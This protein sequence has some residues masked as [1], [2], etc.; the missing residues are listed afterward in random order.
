MRRLHVAFTRGAHN[1]VECRSEFQDLETAL[2]EIA[3]PA[4]V[5][6]TE[7]KNVAELV[8]ECARRKISGSEGHVSSYKAVRGLRPSCQHGAIFRKRGSVRSD[9]D[10]RATVCG[11]RHFAKFNFHKVVRRSVLR[12][13][14][15]LDRTLSLGQ[16]LFLI[17]IGINRYVEDD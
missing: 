14:K 9:V 3:V 5:A 12:L 6:V 16:K 4:N 13:P 10:A 15:V 17:D 8:C 11:R 7:S 1:V 2:T